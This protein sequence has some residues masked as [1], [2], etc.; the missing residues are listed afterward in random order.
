[1]SE[2]Q[3]TPAE[4]PNDELVR[5]DEFDTD[6]PL[7]LDVSVTIGWVEIFLDGSSGARV[8]LRHDRGEQQPWVAGVNSLLSWVGE[9][10]GDQLGVDAAASPAE[11][12]RQSRIETLGN[13]LV[14]PAPK[15][16]GWG[17]HA[18]RRVHHLGLNLIRLAL[19]TG[20]DDG[21]TALL[22]ARIEMFGGG[23]AGEDLGLHLRVEERLP[24]SGLL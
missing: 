2:E 8:E 16:W 11:A 1:M 6:V 19:P 23:E 17:I 24:T 3:T 5:V 22:E 10:F 9:R 13:R 18:A 14:V 7:E 20:K 21:R 4:E 12:V 15:A